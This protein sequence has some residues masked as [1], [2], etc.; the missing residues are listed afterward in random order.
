LRA[1]IAATATAVLVA[2]CGGTRPVAHHPSGPPVTAQQL[3]R[4]IERSGL[5]IEWHDGKAG[6]DV[7]ADLAG[8]ARDPKT[9]GHVAFEIAVARGKAHVT[10]LGRA[11]YRIP[12]SP[13]EIED[14]VDAQVRGVIRNLAYASWF[15]NADDRDAT[16]RVSA[17][18][19]RAIFGAF[20]PTDA[21]AHPILK[22]PPE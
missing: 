10:M 22:S 6:G 5:E 13:A 4:E 2:G 8:D 9:G 15:Y 14:D 20:P 7:I 3:R 1:L 19:D 11:R 21:E 12:H 18:L 16:D 17:R